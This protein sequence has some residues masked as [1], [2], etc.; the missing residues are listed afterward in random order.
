MMSMQI[1]HL[2]P[3]A[4]GLFSLVTVIF[5]AW[6]YRYTRLTSILCNIVWQLFMWFAAKGWL[7]LN[8]RVLHAPPETSSAI[9]NLLA[10]IEGAISTALLLWMLVSLVRW[11][12]PDL[13]LPR[14]P[15]APD[16]A[17]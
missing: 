1:Q 7:V 13:R 15:V 14:Q 9:S 11:G 10:I 12:R 4:F 17:V 8:D 6:L 16:Q 5:L 3:F 2:L